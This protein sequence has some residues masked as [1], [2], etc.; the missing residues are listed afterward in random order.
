[1]AA[2]IEA[3][4]SV[5]WLRRGRVVDLDRGVERE[6]TA[7]ELAEGIEAATPNEFNR[8]RSAA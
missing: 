7:K 1:M 6:A 5:P 4:E 8:K 3:N 2:P